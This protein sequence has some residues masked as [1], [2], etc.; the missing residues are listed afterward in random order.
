MTQEFETSELLVTD[1]NYYS[2]EKHKV[3][4]ELQ[5][6]IHLSIELNLS[7]KIISPLKLNS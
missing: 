5:I 1:K 3:L 2:F 6:R 4:K 7:E